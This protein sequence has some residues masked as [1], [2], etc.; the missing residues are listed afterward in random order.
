MI[1][2]AEGGC[3]EKNLKSTFIY[4]ESCSTSA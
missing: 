2:T 1:M 3:R 4:K